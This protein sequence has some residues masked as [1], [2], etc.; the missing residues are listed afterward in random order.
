MKHKEWNI[1]TYTTGTMPPIPYKECCTYAIFE[2]GRG[3]VAYIQHVWDEDVV[4]E[5]TN[6][7]RFAPDLLV[8]LQNAVKSLEWAADV[9]KDIPAGSEYANALREARVAIN[10]ATRKVI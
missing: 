3:D 2:E 8:A 10:R 9:I 7:I 4:I 6:L 5:N 1:A